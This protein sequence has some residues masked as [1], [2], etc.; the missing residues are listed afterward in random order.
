S[1][2]LSLGNSVES[3]SG[4]IFPEPKSANMDNPALII[5]V[6]DDCFNIPEISY[7]YEVH[8]KLEKALYKDG[9][10]DSI[11]HRYLIIDPRTDSADFLK[12]F[13]S[14]YAHYLHHSI[15]LSTESCK[16]DKDAIFNCMLQDILRWSF[17]LSGFDSRTG[18]VVLLSG[19]KN[20][21][22]GT[23]FSHVRDCLLKKGFNFVVVNP[24][25]LPKID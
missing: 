6:L 10:D 18:N 7:F 8:T 25:T 19:N 23:K 12:S 14:L 22:Q 9:F 16:G 5:W 15:H 11:Q 24:D 13:E 21:G 1:L 20:I 4:I 3:M 2:S 17:V